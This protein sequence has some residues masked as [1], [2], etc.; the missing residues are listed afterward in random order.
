M[1][2][3][4]VA[5]VFAAC[6]TAAHAYAASSSGTNASSYDAQRT[7]QWAPVQATPKA[8]TRA[9]KDGQLAALNKLYR[10]G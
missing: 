1:K 4:T 6:A 9:E 8:K 5:S 10:G 2:A 7:H 3:T